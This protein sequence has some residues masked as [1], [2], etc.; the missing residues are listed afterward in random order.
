M[1]P[2]IEITHEEYLQ[3]IYRLFTSEEG[4]LVLDAWTDNLVYRKIAMEG[5]D[6]LEIGLRQGE[7]NFILS[8][9]NLI[10]QTINK[11]K[12]SKE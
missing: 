1:R 6:P 7:T 5:M 2:K 4:N 9:H 12:G 8:I 3:I 11:E 10:D